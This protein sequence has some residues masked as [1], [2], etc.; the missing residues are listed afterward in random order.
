MRRRWSIEAFETAL[1]AFGKNL[2]RDP[3]SDRARA[4]KGIGAPMTCGTFVRLAALAL[5]CA[6]AACAGIPPV[7]DNVMVDTAYYDTL[8]C[9]DLVTQV[10]G[11][12][13]RVNELTALMQKSAAGTGGGFVNALAYQTDYTKARTLQKYAEEAARRKGCDLTKAAVKTSQPAPQPLGGDKL[14]ALH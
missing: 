5:A 2:G 14:N 10:Q 3:P 12:T 1:D 6:V 11:A 13:A 8:S 4:P 9:P 7:L